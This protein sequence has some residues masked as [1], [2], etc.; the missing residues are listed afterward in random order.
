MDFGAVKLP[1]H[2]IVNLSAT[3]PV[4]QSVSLEGRVENLLDQQYQLV[5]GYNTPGRSLFVA[6]RYAPR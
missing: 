2:G 1:G 5:N 3:F 4:G 6:V